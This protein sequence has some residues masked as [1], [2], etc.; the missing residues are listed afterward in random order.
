M[1]DRRKQ[2]ASA[3]LDNHFGDSGADAERPFNAELSALLDDE[4]ARATWQR[5]ALVGHVMRGDA[6]T[7]Q[8]L[9]ISARVAAQISQESVIVKP[10]V[11][12]GGAMARA[13]SRWLKPA[14]SIAIAASVA[15]VAVLS[16]QQPVVETE[17]ATPS[18]TSPALITNPFG[19]RNP[20]S[21]NTMV[22]TQAPSEA[23]IAQQRQL[24]Q[25]Y[26]LDHQRQ[27]QL[28]LQADKEQQQQESSTVEKLNEQND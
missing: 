16:V 25:S 12:Q 4:Q 5:Y 17:Q 24:L 26:M 19:G 1:S 28:S 3:L 10:S 23:E 9:D 22:E 14:G 8:Q 11:Q 21:Y 18:V 27:L 2:N 6:Q 15:V 7:N 20:V 13:A